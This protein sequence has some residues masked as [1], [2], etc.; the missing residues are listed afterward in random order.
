MSLCG[1]LRSHI[2]HSSMK[3][4]LVDIFACY[5]SA[6]VVLSSRTTR[7]PQLSK[8]VG[9]PTNS[10]LFSMLVYQIR[11]QSGRAV[12]GYARVGSRFVEDGCEEVA[13][14]AG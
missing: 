14:D 6:H 11:R 10:N 8:W 3:L 2:E 12:S 5:L 7:L 9:A 1:T 4:E 13:I